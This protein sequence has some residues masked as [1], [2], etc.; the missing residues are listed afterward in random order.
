MTHNPFANA[1]PVGGRPWS[2]EEDAIL[3]NA[4]KEGT[5]FGDI[6]SAMNR[7]IPA[8]KN[9]HGYLKMTDE[10]RRALNQQ[11][12]KAKTQTIRMKIE[13]DH[14]RVPAVPNEVWEDRNRR[15][16]QPRTLTAWLMGDPAPG[17]S[18]LER[19]A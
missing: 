3:L 6:A 14:E 5:Q 9:R 15:M 11:K 16:A 18:A 19:R 12:T 10:Q 7:T 8:V 17:T 4:R 1:Y 2:A 13:H